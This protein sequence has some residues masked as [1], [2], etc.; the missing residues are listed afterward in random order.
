MNNT[1]ASAYV[2]LGRLC[3]VGLHECETL[4]PIPFTHTVEV[5]EAEDGPIDIGAEQQDANISNALAKAREPMLSK[6]E[7][8]KMRITAEQWVERARAGDQNA[9]SLIQGVRRGAEA[10]K[11]RA[12]KAVQLLAEYIRSHPVDVSSGETK[13]LPSNASPDQRLVKKLT[14]FV[15]DDAAVSAWTPA[16]SRN[17][18][19]LAALIL[20]DGPNMAKERVSAI[21]CHF[22]EEQSD[23]W[24]AFNRWQDKAFFHGETN[25]AMA[26]GRAVGMARTLQ[27]V[28][29]GAFP[30]SRLCQIAGW[31]MGE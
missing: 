8:E 2:R 20:A 15:G 29:A 30:I 16:V 19:Y 14:Q 23:F 11:A 18:P 10:G 1:T 12:K 28:R 27:G 3:I 4:G 6:I 22:G 31:E 17:D 21:G 7:E 5:G 26:T 13:Y 25:D 24:S 9:M